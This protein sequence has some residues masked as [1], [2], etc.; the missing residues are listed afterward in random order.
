MARVKQ[1]TE[2]LQEHL[3]DQLEFLEDACLRYD[4]GKTN[5][6]KQIATALRILLHESNTST[7]LLGQ[8]GELRGRLWLDSAGPV[9]PHNLMTTNGLVAASLTVLDDRGSV[10]TGWSPVLE[11]WRDTNH[12]VRIRT[13]FGTAT[14]VKGWELPFDKWW[15]TPVVNDH[16][17]L[18]SRSD[19]ILAVANT[20]GGA[21]VD[22]ALREP[23]QRLSRANTMGF[24]A[25]GNVAFGSPVPAS[26]RQIAFEALAS[27]QDLRST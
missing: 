2:E 10:A 4:E 19:L 25:N 6:F 23:Y 3:S 20:D 9:N 12:P 7:S 14:L 15:A 24:M 17:A 5:R 27:L 26:V 11:G 13:S 21:H 22:A 16:H 18:F 8:L 1:T